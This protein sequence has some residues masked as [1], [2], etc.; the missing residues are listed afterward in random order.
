MF[1]KTGRQKI[2]ERI[3][4]LIAF[5]E[6]NICYVVAGVSHQQ[7]NYNH[8]EDKNEKSASSA[9]GEKTHNLGCCKVN[10]GF[11]HVTLTASLKPMLRC[12]RS[13][14]SYNLIFIYFFEKR[15]TT[16]NL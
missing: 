13:T 16:N 7:P 11:W 6:I 5:M 4:K 15:N 2:E 12:K 10:L 8:S 9:A 14:T 3:L 1:G